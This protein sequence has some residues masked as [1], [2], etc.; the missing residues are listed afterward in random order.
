MT[1]AGLVMMLA[2]GPAQAT[3]RWSSWNDSCSG[4][5][6]VP[7][8]QGYS[9]NQSWKYGNTSL[10]NYV[11]WGYVDYPYYERRWNTG[12]PETRQVYAEASIRW[13]SLP[14]LQCY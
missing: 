3:V 10:T 7:G 14:Y 1:S 6:L 4:M 5:T 8:P 13:I 9:Y 2:A 12:F 11:N